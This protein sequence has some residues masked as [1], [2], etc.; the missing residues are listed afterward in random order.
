M[1]YFNSIDEIDLE[2][3]NERISFLRSSIEK[4]VPNFREMFQKKLFHI[5]ET[6]QDKEKQITDTTSFCDR[7][8][9]TLEIE[10]LETIIKLFIEYKKHLPE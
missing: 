10:Y 1:N 7:K 5:N 4:P 6:F 9:K 2:K 8:R 3:V